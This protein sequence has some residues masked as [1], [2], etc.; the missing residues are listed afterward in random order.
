MARLKQTNDKN[1]I[2]KFIL[3]GQINIEDI[4]NNG[5]R[6]VHR[7]FSYL[8]YRQYSSLMRWWEIYFGRESLDC[9]GKMWTD[10]FRYLRYF[11]TN[12]KEHILKLDKTQQFMSF[13]YKFGGT[14]VS[15]CL[16]QRLFKFYLW[17]KDAI[18]ANIYKELKKSQKAKRANQV[19]RIFTC[20]KSTV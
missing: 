10:S 12:T 2:L 3:L 13:M 16:T 20:E 18:E 19:K 7:E 4:G 17:T 1:I 8:V 6:K 11:Q 9:K 5:I 14:S 15:V